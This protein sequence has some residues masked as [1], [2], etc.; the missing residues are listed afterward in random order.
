MRTLSRERK[1]GLKGMEK[2]SQSRRKRPSHSATVL[3]LLLPTDCEL[4]KTLPYLS[5]EP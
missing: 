3:P 1:K 5:V 4:L 2:G